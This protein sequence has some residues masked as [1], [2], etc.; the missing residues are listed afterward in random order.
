VHG[1]IYITVVLMVGNAFGDDRIILN[2]DPDWKSIEADP[3]NASSAGYVAPNWTNMS[4]PHTFN[5]VDTFDNWALSGLRGE[6]NQWSG[7]TWYRKYFRLPAAAQGRKVYIEL[8]GVRQ[9]ADVYLNSHLLGTCKN[10]FVPFGFDLT[11][12]LNGE[13]TNVLAVMCDNR[14]MKSHL[15]GTTITTNERART[16]FMPAQE[17]DLEAD[18]MPWNNPQWHPPHGGIYRNVR[19]CVTDPLHISLPLY[20]FLQTAGPYAYATNTSSNAASVSVEVPVPTRSRGAREPVSGFVQRV[21][22]IPESVT[23]KSPLL[24][25]RI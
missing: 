11:P 13:G 1:I 20:D 6:Q 25:E 10:G 12:F 22:Q 4:V 14:F 7:R 5:D 8:E 2:C 17:S 24:G 21:H 15:K 18:Q 23:A 9:V 16:A 3:P 19:L